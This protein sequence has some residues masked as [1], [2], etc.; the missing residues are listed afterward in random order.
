MALVNAVIPAVG[1]SSGA[2]LTAN[3]AASERIKTDIDV[4]L[5][6]GDTVSDQIVFW[7]KNVG[8]ETIAAIDQS[9]VF[10]ESPS[11]TVRIPHWNG[12]G[13]S[14]PDYWVY[15]LENG[16]TWTQAVTA[17]VTLHMVATKVATGVHTVKMAVPNGVSAEKE[18]GI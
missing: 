16:S 6:Y 13:L 1:R 12:E 5:A 14:P 8:T 17:K 10:L 18:F 4:V 7:P 11:A 2:L 3:T 9:D 15:A